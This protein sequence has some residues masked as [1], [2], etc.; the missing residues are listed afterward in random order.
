MGFFKAYDMRGVFGV[1]FDLGIVRDVG[2]ALPSV[3]GGRRWLIGRDGRLSGAAM[4][5]ALAEGLVEAGAEVV[6]M[7]LCTTPMVY[8]FTAVDGYDGSVMITASHNPPGDNG[9]K[10][11]RKGALPVGYDGG[12]RQVEEML[13][14][15]GAAPSSGEPAAVGSVRSGG[16]F[17]ARYLGFLKERARLCAA[18]RVPSRFGV[19]C[20][21]GVA[22]L[23]VH[24]IFPEAVVINDRIDG[25][26]P[27][28]SPNPLKAEARERMS[29]LVRE[30]RLDFGLIFDGDAD[31]VMVVDERGEFV[32]PDYLIPMIAKA[33]AESE[34]VESG[35]VLHDV[36][37]SRAV[38]ETLVEDGFEPVMTPVG[39][40]FAK[41]R[42]RETR[43]L[44]G[45]ELAGHYYFRDFFG[46]DSGF[47]AAFKVLSGFAGWRSASPGGC[48]T[49]S[50][51]M[52]PIRSRYVN[53]G[54]LNFEVADK[55]SAIARIVAH[56]GVFGKE[57]SRTEIDG[58]RIEFEEGW[59]NVRQ[60]NT[61]P[62]LRIVAEA[63]A[64]DVLDGWIAELRRLICGL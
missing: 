2:R 30:R 39:H 26:F 46:C 28:H 49:F 8:Y 1:D 40:A 16:E 24:E 43:A 25:N 19:D 38:I 61:E 54:E 51:M 29:A 6:D 60:S 48:G 17:T 34:G 7:G 53:S 23:L 11:S 4:R 52:A 57:L 59:F 50:E 33:A 12:L 18:S 21:N 63:A 15:C 45:G 14:S 35:K 56:A 5:D 9:L 3:T 31:R 62:L 42:M 37:T 44:C 41:P 47:L 36:R 22:S 10:V 55:A 64:A 20:S 32:Q 13:R 58:V 27:A